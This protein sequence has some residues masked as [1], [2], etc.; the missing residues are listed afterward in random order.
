LSELR[1]GCSGGLAKFGII[2]V[3]GLKF[4]ERKKVLMVS[5]DIVA[6]EMTFFSANIFIC[7]QIRM[8]RVE[9]GS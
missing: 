6:N 4:I 2:Y 7:L 8:G 1:L 9:N 3:A 5:F